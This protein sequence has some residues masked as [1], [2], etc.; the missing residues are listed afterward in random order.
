MPRAPRPRAE[1]T[2]NALEALLN[3]APDAILAVADDGKIFAHNTVAAAMFGYPDGLHDV[4]IDALVPDRVRDR[5]GHHRA[6][7]VRAPR[8]RRYAA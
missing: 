5:H 6:A 4:G 2:V 7:F 8:R 1:I 3:A